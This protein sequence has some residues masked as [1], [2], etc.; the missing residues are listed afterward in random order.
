MFNTILVH[1]LF[2]LLALI[3]AVVPGHDFGLA[4][5]VLTALV[6]FALWPVITKQ[7][8]SQRAMQELA[9]EVA[10][11]RVKAKGDKTLESKLLME[12]Y[13][14]KEIS[15]FASL[16]PLIVQLPLLL[17]LFVVLKDIIKPGEIAH[18][19]Y[20]PLRNFSAIKA[21]LDNSQ[22]FKPTLFGIINLAKPNLVL[23]LIAAGTQYF[24]AKQ[25][26]PKNADRSTQAVNSATTIIF[27]ILT[28]LIALSLPAALPLYW[29]VTSGI[30]LVQ[31]RMILQRDV[32][33][34]EATK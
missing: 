12:L 7:L 10:K 31:Q 29:I 20:S 33:E 18:L 4:V 8:H 32:V 15:P 27:P 13:K 6:R 24:Q 30:A 26:M 1:P 21:V 25:L 11:V 2:N 23:A 19:V 17:A 16:I 5:I 14:E 28:G 9:P 22:A 3:Y 34:M